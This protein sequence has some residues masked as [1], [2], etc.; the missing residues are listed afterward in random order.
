MENNEN[1]DHR[2]EAAFKSINE[3]KRATPK[4]YLLTRINARI[5]TQLKSV[6]EITASFI[7]R[8]LVLV[9]GLCLLITINVLVIIVNKSSK[10]NTVTE[11]SVV[12]TMYDEE[13]TTS[14]ATI[15]NI[16]NP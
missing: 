11:R 6:W 15:D 9:M 12:S 5:D 1:L 14:F 10:N 7:T 16:E 3:I 8:P 13:Y 2:I 4:P